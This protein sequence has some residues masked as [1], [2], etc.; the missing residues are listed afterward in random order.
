MSNQEKTVSRSGHPLPENKQTSL[1]LYVT[2]QEAYAMWKGDPES[3]HVIDVRTPEEYVFVGHPEMADNIPIGYIEQK[4]DTKENDFMFAP[5]PDFIEIV[6]NRYSPGDTLLVMCRAG[7]RSALAVN[8][9]ARAG[10]DKVYNIIDGMEGDKVDDPDSAYHGKR[11][12]DG[13]KNSG[14]PWTYD[15]NLELL[16]ISAA[17]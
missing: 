4:W 15:V 14:T 5:N 8:F 2:S 3:I 12:K 11:M 16:G 7:N 6:K 13:W 9:L 10:F 1:G 17:Q